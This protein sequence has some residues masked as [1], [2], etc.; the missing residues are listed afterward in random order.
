MARALIPAAL[1]WLEVC[2]ALSPLLWPL[3]WALGPRSGRMSS[4]LDGSATC[5]FV[6]GKSRRAGDTSKATAAENFG[7]RGSVRAVG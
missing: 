2:S 1:T 4:N 6:T 5:F 7:V 3:D